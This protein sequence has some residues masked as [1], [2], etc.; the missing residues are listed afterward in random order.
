[1]DKD[2]FLKRI[3]RDCEKHAD[4]FEDWD[5]LMTATTYVMKP[6]GIDIK[7]RKYIRSWVNRYSLGIDPT[8][9]PFTKTEKLNM[10]K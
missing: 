2:T 7:S 9:L 8:P 6:R 10:K 3:G 1:M 5:D 4:K